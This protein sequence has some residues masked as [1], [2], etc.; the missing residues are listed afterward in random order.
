M[1]QQITQAARKAWTQAQSMTVLAL[2]LATGMVL[3]LTLVSM[4]YQAI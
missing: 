3:P 1:T 4:G 2:C